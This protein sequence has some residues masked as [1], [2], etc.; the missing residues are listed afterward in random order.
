MRLLLG[1]ADIEQ[2]SLWVMY[3]QGFVVNTVEMAVDKRGRRNNLI[4]K[5]RRKDDSIRARYRADVAVG[6]KARPCRRL[7]HQYLSKQ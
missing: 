7:F 4:L 6:A 1:V 5:R 2:V 3:R